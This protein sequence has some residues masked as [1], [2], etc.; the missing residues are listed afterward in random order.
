MRNLTNVKGRW[1]YRKV[2]P[3]GLRPYI[4]GNLTEFVR[5]LGEGHG[6]PSPAILAKYASCTAECDALIEL[7][8]KRQSGAFDE[9]SDETITHIITNAR[10]EIL[11]EDEAERFDPVA[12]PAFEAIRAQLAEAG[13]RFQHNPDSDRRWNNRQEDLEGAL[14][15]W[16][17]EY[18]RGQISAFIREETLERC[19]AQGLHVDPES[20]PFHRLARVYLELLIQT[21]E[22]RLK[23]QRGEVIATP[24]PPMQKPAAQLRKP[25]KQTISGLVEDWWKEAKAAGRSISTYEAYERSSRQL[26]EF[27][28]HDDATIVSKEDIVRFKDYRLAQGAS[29]KTVKDGDLS[30]LR[31]L[32]TWGVAN[33][34]I[35]ENPAKDVKVLL[36]KK[37]RSRLKGFTDDEAVT[38]LQHALSHKQQP[39][40]GLKTANAKRWVP[41]LCA[42]TGARVG[43]MAQLRKQDLRQEADTWVITISPEAV[44]VKGGEY[45]EVP[46]HPHLI[47]IGF[48]SFVLE[49][50]DGFLFL[51]PKTDTEK[52]KR[53][54][55]QTVKNRVREFVRE[56][57]SDEDVQ[58]SHGWRH[59]METLMRTHDVRQDVTDAITG[60]TTPGVAAGYGDVTLQAKADAIRKLPRYPVQ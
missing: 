12:E 39:R 49:A 59:R 16:R 44:T 19:L 26:A 22:V 4:D 45:R 60:H 13:T 3:V 23:R 40:E 8:K 41:W 35:T 54:A 32:F 42:Y 9:L 1:K 46:L 57:V 50:E 37:S 18:A 33:G 52:A 10:S 15:L 53:G 7:A 6:H 47:D 56:V 17:H 36:Q 43:E 21:T 38:I 5:W 48:V 51:A 29:P 55:W 20:A 2:I 14:A 58:P 31:A 34:R 11:E 24:E 28:K 27:L 25:P 30:G